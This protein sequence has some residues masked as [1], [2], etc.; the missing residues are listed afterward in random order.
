[1]LNLVWHVA[2]WRKEDYSTMLESCT[3]CWNCHERVIIAKGIDNGRNMWKV[4]II[5]RCKLLPHWDNP[6]SDP[7]FTRRLTSSPAMVVWR[8]RPKVNGLIA[9]LFDQ[10]TCRIQI[11]HPQWP[12]PQAQGYGMSYSL[13]ILCKL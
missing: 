8:H 12:S 7:S 4:L 10:V 2:E 13:S 1:M 5:S 6:L 11:P 9:I 3:H